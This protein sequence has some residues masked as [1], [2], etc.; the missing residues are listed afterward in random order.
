M[1][2]NEHTRILIATVLVGAAGLLALLGR[3]EAPA[4]AGAMLS[5]GAAAV[6]SQERSKAP[7]ATKRRAAS[8]HAPSL[9]LTV[10]DA[11]PGAPVTLHAKDVVATVNGIPVR[12]RDLA[13]MDGALTVSPER[14]AFLK[15]RAIERE[16]ILQ[17]AQSAGIE[18]RDDER[19]RMAEV[20]AGLD[21]QIGPRTVANFERRELRAQLLLNELAAREGTAAPFATQA[22]VDAYLRQNIARYGELPADTAARDALLMK[23]R[24]DLAFEK[25]RAHGEALRDL[26]DELRLSAEII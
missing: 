17:A 4:P 8:E 2:Q 21:D 26:L 3:N 23:V 12:G 5:P 6:A 15:A 14:Y 19:S 24:E 7:L 13:P 25:Q 16:L 11:L 10:P 22:E 9:P 20:V 1:S 18:L